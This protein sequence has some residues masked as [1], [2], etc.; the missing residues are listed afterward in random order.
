MRLSWQASGRLLLLP[1]LM[2]RR[3]AGTRPPLFRC[4]DRT[5]PTVRSL[6]FGLPLSQVLRASSA[7][8]SRP[9]TLT[10]V[11]RAKLSLSLF[12]KAERPSLKTEN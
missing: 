10:A 9:G 7:P 2:L 3:N 11:R 6:L 12:R 1:A 4:G 8:T 5:G